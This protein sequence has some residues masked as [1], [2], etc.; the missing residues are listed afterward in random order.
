MSDRPLDGFIVVEF[1]NLIAAPYAGMLLADLGARVIKVEPPSGDLGRQFGPFQNDESV[2]FLAVNRGK[3]S[4]AIDT[5]D[6]VAKRVLDN[7]VR[8]ADV[9]I[10]NLRHGAMDRLGLGSDRCFE[11]NPNLIYTT[12]SAFGSTGP[13]ASR[14]GID[15]VFQGES[16]MISITGAPEDGPRKTA[17]T[18]GDYVAGT[19]AAFAV[20]AALAESPRRGRLI[21]VS[22]RDGAMAVQSGWNAIHFASGEQ[23]ARTGTASPYL[24]PNQVFESSDRPFTLAVVSDRHFEMMCNALEQ[25]EL[26]ERYPTN[27]ERMSHLPELI[28]HLQTLFLTEPASHWIDLFGSV[29]LPSGLVLTLAEAFDDPQARHHEMVVEYEHPAAGLVRTTGSPIQIDRMPARSA[30]I[31]PELGGNTRR[32]LVELGVD[33]GTVEKM[34]EEGKAVASDL[35]LE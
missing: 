21:E 24:A 3:E 35:S 10:H 20:A 9:L 18:I 5:R 25:P 22:L 1:G 28:E 32:V 26:A 30:T 4:L 14:T 17:T 31:P 16:G 2:F 11:L 15:I 12:I 6:W 33:T 23:P 7:L 13:Y 8:K 19:N 34:I 29:G 27:K